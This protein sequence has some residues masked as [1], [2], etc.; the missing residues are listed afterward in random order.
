[1]TVD[2]KELEQTG[3]DSFFEPRRVPYSDNVRQLIRETQAEVESFEV[4]NGIRKRRRKPDDQVIFEAMVTAILCNLI[5]HHQRGLGGGVAITRSHRTLAMA[6]RYRHPALSAALPPL[7]D[8][9]ARPELGLIEQEIGYVE[10]GS[11]KKKRTTIKATDRL[12]DSIR[13]LSIREED[14]T[15]EPHRETVVLKR[16]KFDYWDRGSE[17]NYRE[18]DLPAHMRPQLNEINNCN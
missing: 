10:D 18:E 2:D 11:P 3:K 15:V 5:H 4:E 6:N 12:I 9:M 13:Q 17:I 1:M 14:L 7:L 8:T 16:D